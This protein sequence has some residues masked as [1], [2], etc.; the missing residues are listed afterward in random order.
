[1][2]DG[3]MDLNVCIKYRYQILCARRISGTPFIRNVQGQNNNKPK[4]LKVVGTKTNQNQCT[5][6]GTKYSV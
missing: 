4:N 1:V 2:I 3:T 5:Q 6:Q